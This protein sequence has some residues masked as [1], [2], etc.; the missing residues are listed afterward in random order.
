M[1]LAAE[2][3]VFFIPTKRT[4]QF[5]QMMVLS[6]LRSLQMAL[7]ARFAL[8]ALLSAGHCGINS[9]TALWQ[10]AMEGKWPAAAR[11]A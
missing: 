2:L 10:S 9:R 11:V 1:E 3:A 4:L 7:L 6:I 8:W 5:L